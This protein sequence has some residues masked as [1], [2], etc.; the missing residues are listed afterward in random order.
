MSYVTKSI[1][2]L[3]PAN[4]A[5]P[6]PAIG[7][8]LG[9]VGI[10]MMKFCKDFNAKSAPYIDDLPLRVRLSVLNDGSYDFTVLTPQSSF[11]V[12][13]MLGVDT[14]AHSPG[15]EVVGAV[16]C[17]QIYELAKLKAKDGGVLESTPLRSVFK[18]LLASCKSYGVD[19]QFE[20]EDVRAARIAAE[21]DK[22]K[23]QVVKEKKTSKKKKT[24]A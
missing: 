23:T 17:K 16:H 5:K 11:F 24:K 8:A 7:Q 2:L 10:N 6:S 21:E 19:V 14:L 3:V 18:S 4:K 15:H 20:R 13:R 9:S 12:K 1:R 22:K